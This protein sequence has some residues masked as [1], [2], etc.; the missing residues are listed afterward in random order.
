VNSNLAA[1]IANP[2]DLVGDHH[3]DPADMKRR[4][5]VISK[6]RNG[7]ATGA[8]RSADSSGAISKA[9]GN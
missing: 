5:V 8:S 3:M 2:G 4:T 7:E 9:V 6:Y 1:Q